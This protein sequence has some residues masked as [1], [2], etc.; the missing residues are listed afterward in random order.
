MTTPFSFLQALE[1]EQ[2]SVH[3]SLAT[4]EIHHSN[5]NCSHMPSWV[6]P[7]PKLWDF[8]V[9]WW[10]SCCCSLSKF[11]TL[12]VFDNKP[13]TTQSSKMK[14]KTLILSLKSIVNSRVKHPGNDIKTS[15]KVWVKNAQLNIERQTKLNLVGLSITSIF[16]LCAE[17]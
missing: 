16:F 8:S 17:P 2:Y 13:P 15:S 11:I 12:I 1:S 5:N 9:L 6:S 14:T 7:C 10:L 3:S 4:P